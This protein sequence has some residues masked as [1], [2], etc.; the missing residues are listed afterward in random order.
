MVNVILEFVV[1]KK[2]KKHDYLVWG[3]NMSLFNFKKMVKKG[4]S[5]TLITYIALAIAAIFLLGILF[6][7]IKFGGP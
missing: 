4:F 3:I 2:I 5:T 1:R 7:K 6:T